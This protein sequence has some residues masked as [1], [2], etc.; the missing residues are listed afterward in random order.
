MKQ[1]EKGWENIPGN[2]SHEYLQGYR[3]I[4]TIRPCPYLLNFFVHGWSRRAT[5][6][7][8]HK[9]QWWAVRILEL[10]A[11]TEGRHD[12][13]K[14]SA[15]VLCWYENISRILNLVYDGRCVFLDL[16]TRFRHQQSTEMDSGID[17]LSN[18]HAFGRG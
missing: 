3:I 11:S 16:K 7:F 4:S 10:E 6:H 8:H 17:L 9:V 18:H 15:G 2:S 12:L 5:L 14:G 1:S 13:F